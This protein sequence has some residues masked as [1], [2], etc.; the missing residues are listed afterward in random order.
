MDDPALI[1]FTSGTTGTPKGVVHTFRSLGARLALN[2]AYIPAAER[3]VT[4]CPLP[5]HFGHG[6]IG[7]A[8]T[9]LLDGGHLLL[10]TEV[11]GTLG[12]VLGEILDEHAVTFMSSVPALWKIATK[13]SSPPRRGS[14]K[15]I[16]VG[17]A[18][19]SASLWRQ[20]ADWAGTRRVFNMYGITEMANWIGGISAEE[21]EPA[22]G[23]VGRIWGGAVL[24]KDRD[25]V[26]HAK[27]KARSSFVR[28][29]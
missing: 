12:S 6:L 17:S 9:A 11:G 5:T 19:L 8:L 22:D 2:Q 3:A 28:R 14:L 15:R 13:M 1:L 23:L 25:G 7:N 26:M 4:L 27:A 20:V 16:H 18:P 21:A 29:R 24:L 10:P